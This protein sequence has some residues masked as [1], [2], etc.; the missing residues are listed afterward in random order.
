[1]RLPLLCLAAMLAVLAGCAS[2][3]PPKKPVAKVDNVTTVRAVRQQPVTPAV[4]AS[5]TAHRTTVTASPEAQMAAQQA[6]GDYYAAL[7]AMKIDKLDDALISFQTLAA[8]HPNLSGPLINQAL[9]YMRKEKPD[10]ALDALNAALKVNPRNPYA[11][12]LRGVLLRQ[13]GKFKEARAAYEQAIGFDPQYAK[14]HF[15]LGV[16]AD[17]YLQD[18]QLALHH[19]EKY[20]ALQKKPDQAVGNWISDLRN[21]LGLPATPVAAAPTAATTTTAPSATAVPAAATPATTTPAAAT[22]ATT[23]PAAAPADAAPAAAPQAPAPAT[24]ST[25]V[26]TPAEPAASTASPTNV[27]AAGAAG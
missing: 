3:P 10:D 14:A 22:P 11:W 21:R 24:E 9:I 15:N 20:Q 27:P 19:Y 13:Q 1:M 6:V 8:K 16:L 25:P 4:A 17:L 2:K 12:N 7:Q 23:A 18:L 26:P 5:D